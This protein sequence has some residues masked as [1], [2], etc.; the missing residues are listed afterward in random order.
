MF[1]KD[2]SST[3]LNTKSRRKQKRA[4]TTG[5]SEGSHDAV[6][7]KTNSPDDTDLDLEFSL[8]LFDQS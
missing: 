7:S 6:I 2:Q 3:P 4:A 8:S 5:Q 1:T